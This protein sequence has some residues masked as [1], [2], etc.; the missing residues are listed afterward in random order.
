MIK[1]TAIIIPFFNEA[2][3]ILDGQYLKNLSRNIEA[4]F[5]YVDDGSTD[6]TLSILN[7]VSKITKAKVLHLK[8]NSGKGEAVRAGLIEALFLGKYEVIGYLDAD[9]AFPASEVNAHVKK[10]HDVLKG[11]VID[12]YIASRIKMSG[13]QIER[14]STR[15]YLSRLILTL[16]G[17]NVSN[18]PYD[19]QSGLKFLKNTEKLGLAV[20]KQF[21]TRWFFDLELMARLGF[22]NKDCTWEEPVDSWRDIAGSKL[23]FRSSLVILKEVFVI[24]RILAKS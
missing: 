10:C 23:G 8:Q 12:I 5:I 16:I 18:M 14:S 22:Q 20:S 19:S 7:E 4:D 13:K 17:F 1:S 11:T 9:G 21:R 6:K 2:S 24:M 15:H 3:R